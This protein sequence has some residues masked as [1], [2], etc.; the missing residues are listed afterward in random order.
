MSPLFTLLWGE[1]A[2]AMMIADRVPSGFDP[3]RIARLAG[4]RIAG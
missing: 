1:E 3:D 4:G 2:K